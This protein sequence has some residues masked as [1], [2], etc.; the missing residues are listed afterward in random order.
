M[1]EHA[2]RPLRTETRLTQSGRNPALQH[3]FVNTP[4]YRGS[5]VVFPTYDALINRRA[6]FHYGTDGT[7]TIAALENAWSELT[8]AAGTVLSP[9]GLGAVTLALLTTLKSGDHLL[10][11]DSVYH[12]TRQLCGGLLA[13]MG[14]TTTYYDPLIGAGIESLIRPETTVIFLE[15]P[16]SQTFEVQ[17]VPAITAVAKRHHVTTVIDNTWATPLF[18]RA[19]EHGCDISLEA[20]TKY[21]GGHSDVLMG[22]VSANA[23]WWPELRKTYDQMA[24][25]PGAEDCFL[26]LRGLRTLHIRLK[27][28]QHRALKV[29]EWLQSRP[30]V[31]KVLHPAFPECPGHEIWKRDFTGSSGLFSLVLNAEYTT[32]DL[33]AMLDGLDIFAMGYSWGGFE[34]LI[35]P[36][37]C[38]RYRTVTDWQPRGLTLRLQ[39]GLEDT[40]DLIADLTAGFERLNAAHGQKK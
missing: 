33:A 7:P 32:D 4:V 34:S 12:P 27:E 29:A 8:G 5:T 16:G 19:H 14:I 18:F 6:E 17:D 28:A 40:E 36:F 10:M 15:S 39:I 2:R 20:G 35:V 9:S 21:P 22:L 24:M 37:D 30:E 23:Q 3:G 25:L 31:S 13:K 1:S 11:T 26:V 38:S